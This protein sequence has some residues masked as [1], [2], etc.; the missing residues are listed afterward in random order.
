MRKPLFSVNSKTN[1]SI[2]VNLKPIG[3]LTFMIEDLKE[4][5]IAFDCEINET[6][7][8]PDDKTALL[9]AKL[10]ISEK[11]E[12]VEAIADKNIL[13]VLD[14]IVDQIYVA[15]YTAHV[16]GLGGILRKAFKLVHENNMSKLGPDGKPIKDASGKVIKP[17]GY[18]PVDLRPLLE[19]VIG[20][21]NITT[22]AP[23]TCKDCS[24]YHTEDCP[25]LNR[26]IL[27]PGVPICDTF[28]VT[29]E[30]TVEAENEYKFDGNWCENNCAP[31]KGCV[32][33]GIKCN[34]FVSK[35]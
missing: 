19:K 32:A 2:V 30:S 27:L 23:P 6:P 3:D 22:T 26:L 24:S 8:V 4:F 35:G 21:I 34:D 33:P 12:T 28:A 9:C 16:Y 15:V 13:E 18:K 25:S 11:S 20:E 5:M 7:T 29:I 31:F 14:G 17:D 10:R 1:D